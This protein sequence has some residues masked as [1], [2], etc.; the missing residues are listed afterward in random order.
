MSEEGHHI[1]VQECLALTHSGRNTVPKTS[2]VVEEEDMDSSDRELL[3]LDE[4]EPGRG[5][6]PLV[7]ERSGA[8]FERVA[9][10]LVGPMPPWPRGRIYLLFMQDFF[11][12]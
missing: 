3:D 12:K 9:L 6:M 11:T 10:D 4:P 7:Q 5:K 2:A 8:P 1:V